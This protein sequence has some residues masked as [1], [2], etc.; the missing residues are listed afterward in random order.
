M[1]DVILPASLN[2][3]IVCE[4]KIPVDRGSSSCCEKRPTVGLIIFTNS[5]A[6]RPI[7]RCSWLVQSVPLYNNGQRIPGYKRRLFRG[8]HACP[9]GCFCLSS[10]THSSS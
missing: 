2:V 1:G 4:G 8:Q 6:A 3:A 9:R 5:G 10:G 7:W